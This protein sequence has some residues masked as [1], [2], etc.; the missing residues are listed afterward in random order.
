LPDAEFGAECGDD[1][2]SCLS[3]FGVFNTAGAANSGLFFASASGTLVTGSTRRLSVTT[4]LCGRGSGSTT[5]LVGKS[6]SAF[7]Q[8]GSQGGSVDGNLF[9]IALSGQ[10][11]PPVIVGTAGAS[12]SGGAQSTG[13]RGISFIVPDSP[14]ARAAA[15]VILSLE[16]PGAQSSMSFQIDDIVVGD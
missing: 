12:T 10:G 15:S 4:E 8:T 7:M 2:S 5:N 16:L 3:S 11:G 1:F 6:I 14:V 9:S 13:W